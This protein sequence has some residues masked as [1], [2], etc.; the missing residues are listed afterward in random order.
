[1][2]PSR[3]LSLAVF[4]DEEK[5][6]ERRAKFQIL[7]SLFCAKS[8]CVCSTFF[9]G[10][11]VCVSGYRMRGKKR[12]ICRKKIYLWK[13]EENNFPSPVTASVLLEFETQKK[14]LSKKSKFECKPESSR[15]FGESLPVPIFPFFPSFKA[16]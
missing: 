7:A 3:N 16:I 4:G 1:M 13:R 15:H 5:K 12:W 11:V 10:D 9:S 2:R 14:D 6:K 8:E